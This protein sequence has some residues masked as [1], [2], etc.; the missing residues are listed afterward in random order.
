MSG[1]RVGFIL[2]LF[3]ARAGA[4][5]LGGGLVLFRGV[6][7]P[8]DWWGGRFVWFFFSSFFQGTPIFRFL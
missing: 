2:E 8:V 7:F 1:V 4:G 3:V 6:F 5:S